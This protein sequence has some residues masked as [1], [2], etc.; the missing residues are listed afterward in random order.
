MHCREL[1]VKYGERPVLLLDLVL[2]LAEERRR[3]QRLGAEA[4]HAVSRLSRVRG[5]CY[6]WSTPR[7]APLRP[8]SVH[9]FRRCAMRLL[10][11]VFTC[12]TVCCAK[13][14]LRAPHAPDVPASFD[15]A[16]RKAAYTFGR[17]LIPRLGAFPDLFYALG[18]NEPA[19]EGELQALDAG[20]PP[21]EPPAA[22]L[23]SDAIYVSPSSQA[24]PQGDGSLDAPMRSLQLAADAAA[25]TVGKTVVLRGGTHYLR[26]PL[27]LE[28]L[29][30]GLSLLGFP[31]EA[32]G[33]T[34][35]PRVAPSGRGR[36]VL[37]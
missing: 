19:C 11:L 34:H 37:F 30:S 9:R 7:S 31:G 16:M 5:R 13:W 26:E 17:T 35:T 2:H 15:C 36:V 20:Q 3:V 24:G 18:L 8:S 33:A 23:P 32:G 10:L 21:P 12:H 4:G 28:P 27:R 1:V 25:R 22:T 29:H 14:P 6:I